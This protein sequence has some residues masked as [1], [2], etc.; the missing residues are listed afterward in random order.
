MYIYVTFYI[1]EIY[2]FIHTSFKVSFYTYVNASPLTSR[3]PILSYAILHKQQSL[4][5]LLDIPSLL[6]IYIRTWKVNIDNEAPKFSAYPRL[7]LSLEGL[8]SLSG[9]ESY[10]EF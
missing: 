5:G 7:S 8:I 3:F 6:L 2:S 1:N 4:K 9:N 10:R